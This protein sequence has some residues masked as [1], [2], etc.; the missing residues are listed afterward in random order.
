MGLEIR[1]FRAL[2]YN[3]DRFGKDLSNLTCPPYD[4]IDDKEREELLSVS[5]YNYVRMVLS[6]SLDESIKSEQRDYSGVRFPIDEWK[7][8]GIFVRDEQD[9][10]YLYRQTYK[11]GDQERQRYG[12]IALLRLPEEEGV[13]LPHENTHRGPKEDRFDLLAQVSAIL[14]PVFFLLPDEDGG[15]LNH[16]K[17]GWNLTPEEWQVY[18][19]DEISKHHCGAVSD[20]GWISHLRQLVFAK[21]ALIADGHHRFEVALSYRDYMRARPDYDEAAWYNYIMVFFA[22][23]RSDNLTVLPIY[24]RIVD[25]KFQGEDKLLEAVD[26]FFDTLVASREDLRRIS[27]GEFGDYTFGLVTRSDS[28]R[29]SLRKDIDPVEV[30]GELAGVSDD[31]KRLNVVVLHYILLPLLGVNQEEGSIVYEKSLDEILSV[32]EDQLGIVLP[33]ISV[34]QI[35]EIAL[36]GERM[37]QKSTYFYPKIRSGVVFFDF[38]D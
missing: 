35:Y 24:R 34:E 8:D 11:V 5:D 2:H 29:L 14:E 36:K 12:F 25:W 30:L 19:R 7:R 13:V 22:P 10:V 27:R 20:K 6:K 9:S 32:E 17:S 38:L 4:V 3:L 15:L 26:R 18:I 23:M 16:I 21:K 1:S 33:P 31:Y 37:P 28:F